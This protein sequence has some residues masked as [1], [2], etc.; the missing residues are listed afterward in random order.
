MIDDVL[1]I[2]AG[3]A[4]LAFARVMAAAGRNVRVI[5]RSR[6]VGGRCATRRID[7]QS[8]DHGLV[9]LHGQSADFLA[10]LREVPG[11]WR[12]GWPTVIEGSGTPCQP[13]AFAPGAFRLAHA[14]GSSALAKHWASGL[15]VVLEARAVG[16]ELRDDGIAVLATQGCP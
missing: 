14:R 16:L 7:G 4:G 2:G 5:E 3:I 15:D 10:A 8:V 12:E 13:A 9:F 1:V 11:P 6:G